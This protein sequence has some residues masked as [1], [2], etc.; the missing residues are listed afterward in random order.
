MSL[1]SCEVVR[2]DGE[3][4][5]YIGVQDDY[6]GRVVYSLRSLHLDGNDYYIVADGQHINVNGYRERCLAREDE[7][8]RALEWYKKTKF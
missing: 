7:I 3:L 8:R 6:T 2:L 4:K 5:A 1:W